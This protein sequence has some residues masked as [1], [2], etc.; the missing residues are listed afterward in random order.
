MEQHGYAGKILRVDLSSGEI[1]HM[2]TME[3]ADRYIGGKGIAVKIY[4]DE[5]SPDVGPFDPDNR[6]MFMAGPLGGISGLSGSGWKVCGKSPLTVPEQY[7]QCNLGGSWGAHL[8]FAGYDGIIVQGQ[9][10][11]PIFLLVHDGAVELRDASALWGKGAIEVREVLKRELGASVRVVACGPAG[12]NKVVFANVLADEDSSGSSGFGAVM[13]SKKLKAIAVTG[14][15]KVAV[16]NPEKVHQYTNYLREILRGQVLPI[17]QLDLGRSS[18]S[19]LVQKK[20]VCYGCSGQ[21]CDRAIY[22]AADKTKGKFHCGGSM[23]YSWLSS[24]YYGRRDWEIQ[25]HATKQCDDWGLDLFGVWM[26]LFWLMRCNEAGILTEENTGIPLSEMGSLEFLQTLVRKIS[27]REG[28]GDILAHGINRAADL[29]G[30]G[31]KEMITDY[32]IRSQEPTEVDPRL[33][34]SAA[35]LFATE[36]RSPREQFFQVI[37]PLGDWLHWVNHSDEAFVSSSIWRAVAREF[38]GSEVAADFSN[39]DG[40]ALAA[41]MVQDRVSINGCLNLC[42]YRWPLMIVKNSDN[43]IGDPALES[44]VFSAVTGKAVDAGE[45]QKM[46]EVIYNL[47]RAVRIR[48]GHRGRESDT[49]PDIFFT[50]P[51]RHH[52]MNSQC[53]LPGKEGEVVCRKGEMLDRNKFEQVKDEYYHLR[54]WDGATG[55]QTRATL[56]EMGLEDV[57]G[58][59]KKRGLSV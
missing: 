19:G 26:T 39:Y 6:L 56:H 4:W 16:A 40:K 28:F 20:Q 32:T 2:P 15:K 53:L 23:F 21:G 7:S 55:L 51:L 50:I 35:M 10:D 41:K 8:K 46:G 59:L 3:Y 57:A 44:K 12:E 25:F 24:K 29:V 34:I 17:Q 14:S 47:E 54:G 30:G 43:H 9:S 38:M 42:A 36:Q 48:E 49:L 22:E 13:G 5:V 31:S 18:D 45:F 33:F 27:L 11:K 1:T 52:Y 58:D 37:Q